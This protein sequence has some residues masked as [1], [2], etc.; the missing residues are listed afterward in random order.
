MVMNVDF[1]PT[2][3]DMAGLEIPEEIQG[4][5]LKELLRVTKKIQENLF[6]IIIMNI[7]YGIKFNHTME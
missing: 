4:K 1:A 2:L 3:L 5:V 6:T 7:R